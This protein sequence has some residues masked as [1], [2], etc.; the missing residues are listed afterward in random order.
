M[1]ERHQCIIFPDSQK[2][3][4]FRLTTRLKD[5]DEQEC[6]RGHDQKSGQCDP[7]PDN[8]DTRLGEPDCSVD[9]GVVAAGC[10]PDTQS[11]G[12]VGRNF[13]GVVDIEEAVDEYATGIVTTND[14][15]V[16][17]RGEGLIDTV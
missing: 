7:G 8:A 5:H 11:G 10:E 6:G 14:G 4:F 3:V 13:G 9:R 2:R 15:A 17:H 12:N 16:H 1:K